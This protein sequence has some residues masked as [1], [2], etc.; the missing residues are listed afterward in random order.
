M[1]PSCC[2]ANH[3]L[4]KT[5]AH[6]IATKTLAALKG[7]VFAG[8]YDPAADYPGRVILFRQ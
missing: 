8:H 6:D 1:A 2:Y 4:K 5:N 7:Y 3:D